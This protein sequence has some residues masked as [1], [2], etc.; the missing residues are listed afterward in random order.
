MLYGVLLANGWPLIAGLVK[1]F[2][3]CAFVFV[4]TF[5]FLSGTLPQKLATAA[6]SDGVAGP[7]MIVKILSDGLKQGWDVFVYILA[8]VSLSLGMFNLLPLPMLDGGHVFLYT[9]EGI[10]GKK[11]PVKAYVIWNM[12]GVALL[13]GLMIYTI[14]SDVAKLL[15]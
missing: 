4:T 7:I 8:M 2:D 12:I 6:A 14:F 11:W 13:G 9:L 15:K 5:Q 10:R 3:M 1:A